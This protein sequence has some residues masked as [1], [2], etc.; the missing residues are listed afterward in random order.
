ME[1]LD[2]WAEGKASVLSLCREYGI[3]PKTAYK[4]R[5]RKASGDSLS[6]RSRRPKSSPNATSAPIVSEV[7]ALRDAHPTLG[8]RK[9]S[10]MLKRR[11]LTD[12]P[13]GSTKTCGDSPREVTVLAEKCNILQD[14][15]KGAWE[16]MTWLR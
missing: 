1:F 3:S 8:G 9:I 11:G 2:R 7:L 4:W 5:K 15:A 14:N 13:A 16:E 6:D 10:L 12:V